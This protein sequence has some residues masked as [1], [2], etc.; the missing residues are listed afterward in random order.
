MKRSSDQSLIGGTS[1]KKYFLLIGSST[2]MN[3]KPM[4]LTA[5]VS[6][7]HS[8]F[9]SFCRSSSTDQDCIVYKEIYLKAPFSFFQFGFKLVKRA[10]GAV[11]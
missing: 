1:E 11:Q 2:W 10:A 5:R 4:S 7:M 3:L 9:K 6:C 8:I